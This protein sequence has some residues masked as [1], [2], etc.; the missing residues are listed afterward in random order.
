ML[1]LIPTISSDYWGAF[2][3]QNGSDDWNRFQEQKKPAPMHL[4]QKELTAIPPQLWQSAQMPQQHKQPAA[5]PQQPQDV[6]YPAKMVQKQQ[7][8]ALTAMPQTHQQVWH[9]AE[10]PQQQKQPASTLLPQEQLT[11]VPQQVV[12][13]SNVP[14]AIGLHDSTAEATDRR[15]SKSG[16]QL[17]YRKS[18]RLLNHCRTNRPPYPSKWGI[19]LKCP[20]SRSN[21]LPCH[22]TN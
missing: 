22:S 3:E 21:T 10:F 6:W 13:S 17:K 12:S 16:N 2:Q 5:M 8:A 4:P 14:A 9:P 7:V 18:N 20:S 19:Q 1:G 15:A 11:A